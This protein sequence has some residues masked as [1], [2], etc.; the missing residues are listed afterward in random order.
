MSKS[1]IAAIAVVACLPAAA[2]AQTYPAKPIRS[3]V[4]AGG[5]ADVI[6]RLLAQKMA[7]SMGQPVIAE[8]GA[9]AGGSIAA[10]T[11]AR[12]AP[13]GYTIMY[14]VP[15][16]LVYRV[17]LSKNVPYDPVRDFTPLANLGHAA[18]VV[19]VPASSPFRNMSDVVAFA[20]KNPGK[21]EY[22][23][24]GVGSAH[25][26]SGELLNIVSGTK[27]LHV[28]YKDSVQVVTETIAGRIPLL[29]TVFGAANQAVTAG[30]LRY[31]GINMPARYPLAKDVPTISE[32][33]AGYESP[34]GWSAY[35]GP[36]G[37]PRPLVMRLNQEVTKAL[38][39]PS[40]A[41]KMLGLGIMIETSTPEEL[42][43]L[44]KRSLEYAGKT[45]KAAGIEP[46]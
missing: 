33:V 16:P 27:M 1:A 22:G 13:D 37:M 36:A 9:A 3:L 18:L 32:Q 2:S 40:V 43:A 46:E 44:L 12:A 17:F 38:T 34:P 28:P 25:H 11:V 35:F 6:A 15:T 7:E 29:F 26:L 5:P 10:A 24:S 19:A 30:S 20:R 39:D 41:P 4:T 31:L 14:G 8:P 42:G 21:L 45:I 23:T